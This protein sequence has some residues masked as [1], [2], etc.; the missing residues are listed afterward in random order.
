METPTIWP[1]LSHAGWGASV[2]DFAGRAVILDNWAGNLRKSMGIAN[3]LK[4]S[5]PFGGISRRASRVHM[6]R[7]CPK[8]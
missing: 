8:S 6:G 4:K 5:E 3:V 1:L 7:N 2:V